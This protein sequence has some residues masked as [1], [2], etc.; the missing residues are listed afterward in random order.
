M[1]KINEPP[2]NEFTKP[3]GIVTSGTT[4]ARAVTRERMATVTQRNVRSLACSLPKAPV[5]PSERTLK[6]EQMAERQGQM[7]K[8]TDK[9]MLND[10][11]AFAT[12]HGQL[13][14]VWASVEL[15]LKSRSE[16]P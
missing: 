1:V 10:T 4:E 8:G 13:A 7:A 14:Q 12:L 5:A 16:S 6:T 3:N 9:T 15:L 11:A 2:A